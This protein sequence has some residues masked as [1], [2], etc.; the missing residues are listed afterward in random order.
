MENRKPGL[1]SW[2]VWMPRALGFQQV[3]RGLE[4]KVSGGGGRAGNMGRSALIIADLSPDSPVRDQVCAEEAC[5][6]LV[7]SVLLSGSK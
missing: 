1:V 5:V 6:G 4:Q 2:L 7:L 3:P